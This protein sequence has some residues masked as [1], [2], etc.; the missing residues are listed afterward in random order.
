MITTC[1]WQFSSLQ[2]SLTGDT[3]YSSGQDECP[4]VDDQQKMNSMASVEARGFIMSCQS[5]PCLKKCYY[6]LLLFY[7]MHTHTHFFALC[8]FCVHVLSYNLVF[9]WDS[10]VCKWM[11]L[12]FCWLLLG[13]FPFALSNSVVLV[14]IVSYFI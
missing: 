1:K 12:C 3:N 8:V 13:S 6:F 14:F 11:G 9:L 5:F 7:F 4:A 10:W 2:G